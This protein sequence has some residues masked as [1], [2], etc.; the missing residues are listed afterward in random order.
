MLAFNFCL[1]KYSTLQ[2]VMRFLSLEHQLND[3]HSRHLVK[4][5]SLNIIFGG[6]F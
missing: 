2:S 1:S 5:N 4:I 6:N 3:F